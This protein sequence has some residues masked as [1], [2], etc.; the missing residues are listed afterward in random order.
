MD[1][2]SLEIEGQRIRLWGVDAPEYA[3]TCMRDARP[4][5]CGL[6]AARH[7][8]KFIDGRTLACVPVATDAYSRAVSK[9]RVG[10][11]DLN[12][13]LVREGWALDYRRYSGGA[14]AAAQKQARSARRGI[15]SGS[16]ERPEQW[17]RRTRPGP[18]SRHR[19]RR[20][21]MAQPAHALLQPSQGHREHAIRADQLLHDAHR[22]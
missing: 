22:R 17:R 3:Q 9:C 6:A 4:W 1:G 15:W 12:E 16:F 19:R 7:L 8:R 13:W 5:K 2:D 10:G 18:A 14:Y 21:R 11:Q 20:P